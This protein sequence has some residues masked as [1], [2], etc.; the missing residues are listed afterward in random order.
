MHVCLLLHVQQHGLATDMHFTTCVCMCKFV[1]CCIRSR[2][3]WL[4]STFELH[5][6]VC[7]LHCL[8][9]RG[10]G[11]WAT[12]QTGCKGSKS[13]GSAFRPAGSC[14]G[15]L[16]ATCPSAPA[17]TKALGK[18]AF[19]RCA[20]PASWFYAHQQRAS[21]SEWGPPAKLLLCTP[22]IWFHAH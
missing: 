5:V 6:Q 1:C 8:H 18:H 12:G 10:C 20:A 14:P 13:S 21:C 22:G 11:R 9:R 16:C 3:D 15:R 17:S 19:Q 2:M 7:L 4:V